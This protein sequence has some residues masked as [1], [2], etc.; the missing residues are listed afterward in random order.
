MERA[1]TQG[2]VVMRVCAG[3][4]VSYAAGTA[5][6]GMKERCGLWTGKLG[7]TGLDKGGKK[8]AVR[9]CGGGRGGA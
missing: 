7:K 8:R 4:G 3:G 5:Y 6:I 9:S 1:G 2:G